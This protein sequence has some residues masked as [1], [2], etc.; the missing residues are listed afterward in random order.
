MAAFP[1]GA[2]PGGG[3]GPPPGPKKPDLGGPG[4]GATAGAGGS[5]GVLDGPRLASEFGPGWEGCPGLGAAAEGRPAAGG[6]PDEALQRALPAGPPLPLHLP[7]RSGRPRPGLS[8]SSVFLLPLPTALGEPGSKGRLGSPE[9]GWL[10]WGAGS[11]GGEEGGWAAACGVWERGCRFRGVWKGAG[12]AGTWVLRA[13][14][15]WYLP[16]AEV[17]QWVCV[18]RGREV[19]GGLKA[20][21]SRLKERKKFV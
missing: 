1:P 11:G 17:P 18:G 12:F 4:A 8:P 15:E 9:R 19:M 10:V 7:G 5:S 13:R 3:A 21:R 2:V 14:V 16:S 6:G 20:S